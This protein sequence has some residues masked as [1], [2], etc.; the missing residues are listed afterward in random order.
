[1]LRRGL[2]VYIFDAR[3]RARIYFFISYEHKK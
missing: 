3:V 2:D 1:M